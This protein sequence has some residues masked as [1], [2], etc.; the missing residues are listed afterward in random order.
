MN[1]QRC[2]SGGNPILSLRQERNEYSG[3]KHKLTL[4][5]DSDRACVADLAVDLDPNLAI[6]GRK[7]VRQPKRHLGEIGV[8]HGAHVFRS[9]VTALAIIVNKINCN[10]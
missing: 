10:V 6:A 8:G 3:Y 4:R 5:R 1:R 2:Y 7:T 9:D